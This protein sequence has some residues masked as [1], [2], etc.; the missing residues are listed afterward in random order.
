MTSAV[1]VSDLYQH[2]SEPELV[3]HRFRKALYHV[4]D[5]CVPGEVEPIVGPWLHARRDLFERIGDDGGEGWFAWRLWDV[6][7]LDPAVF[8]PIRAAI[9]KALPEALK[10]C[11]I[12]EFDVQGVEMHATLYHH[13]CHASWH[14][15]V[16]EEDSTR[17]IAFAYYLRTDP[18]LFQGGE[19]EFLDGTAIE[20]VSR[21]AVFYHPLQLHRVR[22]IECWAADFIAG[23]WAIH[24]WVLGPAT[25]STRSMIRRLRSSAPSDLGQDEADAGDQN[26][27]E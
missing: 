19:L 26:R 10:D 15:D 21:R 25:D 7:T 13:K 17:R 18:V 4:S 1:D 3:P 2:E 24:G 12:P 11:A 22:P 9:L 20:P 6:D 5:D 8:A 23:R 27:S 14:E 16:W